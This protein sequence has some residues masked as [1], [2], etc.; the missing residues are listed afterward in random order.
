MNRKTWPGCM[1]L[2]TPV[3]GNAGIVYDVSVRSVDQSFGLVSPS[4]PNMPVVSQYFVEDGSIRVGGPH[5]K[6]V[7]LFKEQ[8]LYV[9]DNTSQSVHI[10]K[11]A[12]LNEVSAHYDAAVK[13]LESAAAKAAPD[14]RLE[15]ERRLAQMKAASDRLRQTVAREYRMTVRFESVD[16]HACRIWEERENDAKRLELCVAPTTTLPGGAEILSGIRTLSRFRQGSKFA[17]GVDFGL[18]EWWSDIA[19]LAGVPLLIREFKYDS[20]ATEVSLSAI[21][22]NPR[23]A[24]LFDLPEGYQTQEGSDYSE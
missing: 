2:L 15:A 21:R 12:T 19:S 6:T 7:R 24:S 14:D 8:T 20:L 18:S 11:H 9:I 16:G 10:L 17:L 4:E 22:P 23:N 13:Q 1:L 3:F 5:A